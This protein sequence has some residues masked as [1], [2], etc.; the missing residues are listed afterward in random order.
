[1][2]KKQVNIDIPIKRYIEALEEKVKVSKVVLYGS[3]VNGQPHE[4]SDIDLAVF[5]PDFGKNK[6]LE[7]QLLSKLSWTIDESIDSASRRTDLPAFY[8]QWFANRIKAGYFYRITASQG[9]QFGDWL[10]DANSELLAAFAAQVPALAKENGIHTFTCSEAIDLQQYGILPG[11]CIDGALINEVF[12]L[13]RSWKKDP[14]QRKNCRCVISA[15]MGVYDTC[16]FGCA[17]C[18]ANTSINAVLKND[19]NRFPDSPALIG[20]YQGDVQ[21]ERD[22]T[23]SKDALD[24][25]ISLL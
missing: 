25:Q 19:K 10:D 17:Y 12:G 13:K 8:G 6:L 5:S 7:L 9:V 15:D 3:W 23:P 11:S 20:Q 16:K 4:Y 22:S 21:I 24:Q 14:C 1:M 18:Y 2:V